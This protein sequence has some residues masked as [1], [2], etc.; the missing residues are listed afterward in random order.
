MGNG[1]SVVVL[2]G[3]YLY[4]GERVCQVVR[5]MTLHPMVYWA[6]VDKIGYADSKNLTPLPE[7]LNPILSDSISIKE[8]L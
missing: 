5:L 4:K 7:G 8:K 6:D 2:G 3:W 1:Q